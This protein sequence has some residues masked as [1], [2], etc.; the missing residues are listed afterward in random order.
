MKGKGRY[1]LTAV[2]FCFSLV[3]AVPEV[4]FAS[5]SDPKNEEQR[6]DVY[7]KTV[8]DNVICSDAPLVDGKAQ[9]ILEDGR[10]IIVTQAPEYAEVLKVAVIPESEEEAWDWVKGCLPE[11]ITV[12][13][14]YDIYFEDAE[15]NRI[16][17]DGAEITIKSEVC[18]QA[19]YSVSVG[20]RVSLLESISAN[21]SI[22]FTADGAQYYVITKTENIKGDQSSDDEDKPEE[23]STD[24]KTDPVS[25]KTGDALFPQIGGM[26]LLIFLAAAALKFCRK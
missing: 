13:A 26:A 8:S 25:A 15:G 21:D 19:V 20:G 22:T 17:A 9:I 6:I 5:G 14:F 1:L 16:N 18:G 10:T 4:S 24:I 23:I 7:A 12:C 2:I 11:G 3:W